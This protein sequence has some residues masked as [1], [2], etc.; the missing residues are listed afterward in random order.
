MTAGLLSRF[1]SWLSPIWNRSELSVPFPAVEQRCNEPHQEDR[2]CNE[3][4]EVFP[5][6]LAWQIEHGAHTKKPAKNI[7]E[8]KYNR[9]GN[10]ESAKAATTK[11]REC[12]RSQRQE[13][14]SPDGH[15]PRRLEQTS[16][17]D[18]ETN[19]H[20]EGESVAV[21]NSTYES[22]EE[23]VKYRCPLGIHRF[24]LQPR[25]TNA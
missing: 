9:D 3:I 24:S 11:Q 22:C 21:T 17:H 25:A 20:D 5:D 6:C 7:K 2:R 14:K 8:W 1:S 23:A 18:S 12:S 4:E 13:R 15:C 16:R 10:E 19:G